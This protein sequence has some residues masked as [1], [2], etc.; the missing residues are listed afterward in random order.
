MGRNAHIF[1]V[2]GTE[3][4]GL[5]LARSRWHTP[6]LH[7]GFAVFKSITVKSTLCLLYTLILICSLE[8][9]VSILGCKQ[10][11][12]F[13]I[14]GQ[15][16]NGHNL[17]LRSSSFLSYCA[18][19]FHYLPVLSVSVTGSLLSQFIQIFGE[20][21]QLSSYRVRQQIW[22]WLFGWNC[23]LNAIFWE[24]LSRGSWI[25]TDR[26]G[27]IQQRAKPPSCS[28]TAATSSPPFTTA[29]CSRLHRGSGRGSLGNMPPSCSPPIYFCTLMAHNPYICPLKWGL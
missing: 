14:K 17:P 8:I 16:S 2:P 15:E 26:S 11:R 7:I 27:C 10:E 19:Q 24:K 13:K 4:S 29:N 9:I 5:S 6:L 3:F 1:H 22:K 25:S 18:V 12:I 28:L 20:N 23:F 21:L